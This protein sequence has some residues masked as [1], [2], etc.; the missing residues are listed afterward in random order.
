MSQR[1]SLSPQ[2]LNHKVV[3]VLTPKAAGGRLSA[4][5]LLVVIFVV[6]FGAALLGHFAA[7]RS[8]ADHEAK[9]AAHHE[10]WALQQARKA[11]SA[12]EA[13]GFVAGGSG[14]MCLDDGAFR[15]AAVLAAE[16]TKVFDS[17]EALEEAQCPCA[18]G[19]GGVDMQGDEYTY[20]KRSGS[21]RSALDAPVLGDKRYFD[22]DE[23]W[24]ACHSDDAAATFG[25]LS[26]DNVEYDCTEAGC[27]CYCQ[28]S[29]DCM[30]DVGIT[31]TAFRATSQQP[32]PS[33]C[34]SRFGD[35]VGVDDDK[36]DDD[37]GRV[38][39]DDA[40]VG[41]PVFFCTCPPDAGGAAAGASDVDKAAECEFKLGK[42][43]WLTR[44]CGD[45]GRGL[46]FGASG[47]G[48]SG[49]FSGGFGDAVDGGSSSFCGAAGVAEAVR[50]AA[51]KCCGDGVGGCGGVCFSGDSTVRATSPALGGGER[52]VPL[53][54]LRV[55]DR[56][57]VAASAKGLVAPAEPA[58]AATGGAK[59]LVEHRGHRGKKGASASSP[60]SAAFSYAKVLALPHARSKGAG[61]LGGAGF[62]EVITSPA[63]GGEELARLTPWHTLPTCCKACSP[64]EVSADLGEVAAGDLKPGDCVLTLRGEASVLSVKAS[65][66]SAWDTTYTLVLDLP[67]GGGGEGDGAG[68]VVAVGGVFVHVR[69]APTVHLHRYRG[70]F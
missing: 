18:T 17:L 9:K 39:D 34:T 61:G 1:N 67:A 44:T 3:G 30:S 36:G 49:G 70:Q 38:D 53:S 33:R 45:V 48:F 15:P 32:T 31:S 4:F 12:A 64:E 46:A 51:D 37:G 19:V 41:A 2:K 47:S 68:A 13:A 40:T 6:A 52:E 24:R 22:L 14:G 42:G 25:G 16:C 29:C 60:F 35:D 10:Q 62:V 54:Q 8:M 56:V 59:S 43:A 55:G 7:M 11:A 20:V 23:C 50:D 58:E 66:A 5:A 21:C 57:L 69:P 26:V 65:P 63:T 28:S 27:W